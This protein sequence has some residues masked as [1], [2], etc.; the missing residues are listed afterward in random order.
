MRSLNLHYTTMTRYDESFKGV[1]VMYDKDNLK[2]TLG[3][4]IAAAKGTQLRIAE[5]QKY[6]H[7]TFFF[8]GG[9]EDKFENEMRIMVNS[10]KVAT[11]DLQPEMSADEV[12]E[13]CIQCIKEQGPD[14][15]CLNFANPDMVGH[16]G[17][18]P[19][20]IKAVER[21]DQRMN[22]VID[23]A[24]KHGYEI[25]VIADHGN[26]DQCKMP[27]GTP[28]TAHTMNPVPC[29]YIGKEKRVS[30]GILADVA[31]TI[32]KLME[33]PQPPEM[34]GKSLIQ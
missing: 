9:R 23:V 20:I 7:V 33:I 1:N 28:H 26:A 30:D 32:L 14:F 3:E 4:V 12:T 10:P 29:I 2:N 15:I 27:D 19:A 17:I 31:P 13:K 21:V 5:T 24:R 18:L 22:D 11:Y 16:T 25:I 8:S 6:P 34:T